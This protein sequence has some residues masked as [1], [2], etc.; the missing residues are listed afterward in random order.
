MKDP[1]TGPNDGWL[2]SRLAVLLAIQGLIVI[3]VAIAPEEF[4]A[5]KLTD[6]AFYY[7]RTAQ[8]FA[9][10]NGLT[11]DG[12]HPTNGVQP[13]WFLTLV[14]V[15]AIFEGIW[16]PIRVS[17]LLQGAIAMGGAFLFYSA[18]STL[19]DREIATVTTVIAWFNPYVV[20][21]YLG[22]HEAAMN[23]LA[24]SLILYLLT[25]MRDW[26][27]LS[28]FGL[29]GIVCGL[30]ILVRLDNVILVAAVSGLLVG[31]RA[32]DTVKKFVVYTATVSVLPVAYGFYNVITFGHLVPVSGKVLSSASTTVVVTYVIATGGLALV[33]LYL[34][35]RYGV[36]TTSERGFSTG[37]VLTTFGFVGV[38]HLVYYILFQTRI[39]TWYL[40]IEIISG[41]LIAGAVLAAMLRLAVDRDILTLTEHVSV[42]LVIVIVVS[43]GAVG[44]VTKLD[45]NQNKLGVLQYEQGQYLNE[46]VACDAII[47]SGN[48]GKVGYF[49]QRRVVELNGL[50]NSYE[51]VERFQ[52]NHSKYIE[53][54]QPAFLIDY[55]PHIEHETLKRNN[56][57][58]IRNVSTTSE[59]QTPL[60]PS[61]VFNPRQRLIVYEIWMA[62]GTNLVENPS[63]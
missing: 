15:Y 21:A 63:C 37:V 14:P 40:P 46:N 22:G 28:T 54:E 23:L 27:Q 3:A 59:V 43:Y 48:A 25:T 56:Y 8:Q 50:I 62:N 12:I 38:T 60:K 61:T 30:A 4:L 49:S 18:V 58:Q 57:Q 42:G 33:G 1:I 17:I 34:V 13:V 55:R 35:E 16:L 2:L 10:G 44:A 31:T 32:V 20:F 5:A 29:V 51:F 52:G 36:Q 24:I 41:T 9:A 11:F 47:G 7:F 53:E 6:D 45:T 39:S 26:D 19:Y